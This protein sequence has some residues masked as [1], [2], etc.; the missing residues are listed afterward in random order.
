MLSSQTKISKKP[1]NSARAFSLLALTTGFFACG[2]AAYQQLMGKVYK[3]S[4]ASRKL[5]LFR[6]CG[7]FDAVAGA[8]A[9]G[10]WI[11]WLA[12]VDGTPIESQFGAGFTFSILCTFYGFIAGPIT[13]YIGLSKFTMTKPV[14]ENV[15]VAQGEV[16]EREEV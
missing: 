10:T 6:M 13:Y 7:A 11:S 3:P 8:F 14:P 12:Y 2:L 16:D 15:P 1:V 5:L 4:H 9:A